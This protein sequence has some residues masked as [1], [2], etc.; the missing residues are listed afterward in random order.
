MK[1]VIIKLGSSLSFPINNMIV[2][3][4]ER[5][6]KNYYVIDGLKYRKRKH[7]VNGVIAYKKNE[8]RYFSDHLVLDAENPEVIEIHKQACFDY[9]YNEMLKEVRNLHNPKFQELYQIWRK[10]RNGK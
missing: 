1:Q 5:E 7:I 6:T 10:L 4:V 3:E 8:S 2:K 9:F